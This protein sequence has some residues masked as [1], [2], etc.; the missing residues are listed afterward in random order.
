MKLK[1]KSLIKILIINYLLL[2]VLCFLLLITT[3]IPN[4]LSIMTSVEANKEFSLRHIPNR[5]YNFAYKC[6]ESKVYYNKDGNRQYAQNSEAFKVALLGDSMIENAQL[7]DGNDLGS[8]LQ[9]EL[10]NKFE[11][12]NFGILSTGIYDH[13]QIYR[14]KNLNN[15][16]LIIYFIDPT[17]IDDNHISRNRPNQNMF[18]IE[19]DEIQKLPY[20]EKYCQN[21][22]STYNQIKRKHLFYIKKYSNIYKV[23]WFLK[24]NYLISKAQSIEEEES[25]SE[26]IED[27]REP[28]KIYEHFSKELLSELNQNKQSYLVIPNLRP[29]LFDKSE[30]EIFKYN[31][32]KNIWNTESN[33]IDDPYLAAIKYMEDKNTYFYPYL[34]W[35]CDAHYSHEEANFFSKFISKKIKNIDE[36]N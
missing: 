9:K 7:S 22:F 6:W 8:L 36:F 19:N 26:K 21:Y 17:D 27:L 25:L 2:E 10:G 15:Y 29:S 18:K 33:N 11:V 3:S 30:F 32:L 35:D 12:T 34:S 14:K 13:L 28:F 24:E 23:Y 4:G 5:S 20:D 1:I 16:D 31:Y